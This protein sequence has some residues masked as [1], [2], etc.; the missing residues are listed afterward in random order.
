MRLLMCLCFVSPVYVMSGNEMPTCMIHLLC[1]HIVC[2]HVAVLQMTKSVTCQEELGG[3][4]SQVTMDYIQLAQQGRLAATT[5]EP[6][7]V[8]R[9]LERLH[10]NR[11]VDT[12]KP[13]PQNYLM[14]I[15]YLSKVYYY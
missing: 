2:F 14:N 3:L 1:R 13:D 6:E 8:N 10:V 11:L 7:E 9:T 4:A 15:Q 5:A 12:N